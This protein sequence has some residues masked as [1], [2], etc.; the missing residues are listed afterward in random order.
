MWT[1][2]GS[3]C[4]EAWEGFPDPKIPVNLLVNTMVSGGIEYGLGK[5]WIEEFFGWRYFLW[6]EFGMLMTKMFCVVWY[7]VD[8]FGTVCRCESLWGGCTQTFSQ[9]NW[10]FNNVFNPAPQGFPTCISRYLN[11][12]NNNLEP[13]TAICILIVPY[14]CFQLISN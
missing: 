9:W 2:T 1:V 11:N 14:S 6:W 7:F 12:L 5:G 3:L 10:I 8:D 13:W 4:W